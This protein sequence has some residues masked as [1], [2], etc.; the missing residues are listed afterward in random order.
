MRLQSVILQRVRAASQSNMTSTGQQAQLTTTKNSDGSDTST[1]TLIGS[2]FPCNIQE[3]KGDSLPMPFSQLDL[4]YFNL[5]IP[6]T[7]SF[8]AKD[9][10]YIDGNYFEVEDTDDF[11]SGDQIS[12]QYLVS[13]LTP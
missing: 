3:A 5:F 1:F 8:A 12:R 7:V 10:V 6:Y 13:K 2:T 11:R 4:S 9:K